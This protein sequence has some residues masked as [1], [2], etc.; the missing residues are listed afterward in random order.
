MIIKGWVNKLRMVSAIITTRNRKKMLRMALES[1]LSQTYD[2]IECI[3][4]DDAGTD[5]TQEYIQ[6]LIDKD[7]VQYIYITPEE[8]RGG[9]HARNVGILASRGEYIAFLDDDDEWLP[10]KIEKQVEAMR[11]Q[12]VGFVYC[13]IIREKNF[14]P[15]TRTVVP[16]VE[17]KFKDGDISKDVLVR[18][19]ATTSTIMIRKS[20]LDKVG[21]FDEELKFWQEY[22]LSI[23][24][25]Q[26]T[27]AKCIRDNLIL[28]RIIDRDR[29]RLSNKIAGWEEA[30]EY[31][32][33]KHKAL[34]SALSEK[35]KALRQVY[36]C[37]DGFNRGKSAGS[38]KTMLKYM[39]RVLS[40]CSMRKIFV[41]KYLNRNKPI[42][43]ER[44]Y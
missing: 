18:I 21:L 9:N 24:V 35:D 4:V 30:V 25:L 42:N 34:F 37:I 41:N 1:V 40:N 20:I 28:Y 2:N 17:S 33:R 16:L 14:D 10:T 32:E 36:I 12:S 44:K 43:V 29:N 7:K 13:G 31:I 3:V 39:W 27:K 38:Y 11:D 8:S 23:R 19:I 6:D 22:E 15:T 26:K 5:S